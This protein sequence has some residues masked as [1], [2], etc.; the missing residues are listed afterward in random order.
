MQL[1]TMYDMYECLRNTLNT[2]A[3]HQPLYINGEAILPAA[4]MMLLEDGDATLEARFEAERCPQPVAPSPTI[5][6]KVSKYDRKEIAG[7]A[8]YYAKASS[9]GTYRKRLSKGFEDAWSEAKK[10]ADVVV[11]TLNMYLRE[12]EIKPVKIPAPI[13]Y[14]NGLFDHDII[15]YHVAQYSPFTISKSFTSTRNHAL[16]Y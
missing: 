8:H 11:K 7:R 2:T 1:V 9:I 14:G 13:T 10:A 3:A 6:K 4:L 12:V 16:R 5:S 15:F